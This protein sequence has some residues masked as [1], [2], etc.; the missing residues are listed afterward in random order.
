MT[1]GEEPTSP[2]RRIG[3]L[4][5]A[6]NQLIGWGGG[7]LFV[8]LGSVTDYALYYYLAFAVYM[9]SWG[10]LI[11][12]IWLTGRETVWDHLRDFFRAL[13]RPF[14]RPRKEM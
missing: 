14:R 4:F 6:T 7:I 2:R 10:L 9:V 12:G 13:T 3:I 8:W 1:N 11:L 5:L